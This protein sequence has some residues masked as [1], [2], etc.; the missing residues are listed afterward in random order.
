M[1]DDRFL[2][3][4]RSLQAAQL[5]FDNEFYDV[6]VSRCYYA[7]F[8]LVQELL[9]EDRIH[10]STHKGLISGFGRK[11]VKEGPLDTEFG[12]ILNK[13]Y[14]RRMFGD[15][16]QKDVVTKEM[17]EIALS[18]TKKFNEEIKKQFLPK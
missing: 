8:Y 15:Y 10:Y 7:M 17:A 1:N 4:D 16:G 13:G 2:L 9:A 18:E 14:E 3:S 11:F 5:L 6:C 12:K